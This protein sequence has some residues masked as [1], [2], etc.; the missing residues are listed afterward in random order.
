MDEVGCPDFGEAT[1]RFRDFLRRQD[2]PE[3]IVWVRAG[4]VIRSPG[5][6]ITICRQT[7]AVGDG[8]AEREYEL[9]RRKGL[10]VLLDAVC[11]LGG[12]TCAIVLYPVDLREAELLMYPSDGGLK[13]SV[14]SASHRGECAMGDMLTRG[15]TTTNMSCS[16]RS[17]FLASLGRAPAA[18]RQ[19]VRRLHATHSFATTRYNGG[20]RRL[21][22]Q[23]GCLQFLY[24]GIRR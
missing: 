7:D 9:A 13:L 6:A 22:F 24:A 1:R 17:P 5:P 21:H 23:C 14:A 2:W 12:A 16:G 18:E 3:Q 4:D 19:D 15:A 11:T 20:S 8:H 10:G